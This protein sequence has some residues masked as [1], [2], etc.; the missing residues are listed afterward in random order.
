MTRHS[1]LENI[2]SKNP[3]SRVTTYQYKDKM[4]TK[5]LQSMNNVY[6]HHNNIQQGIHE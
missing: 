5:L 2:N 4:N 6:I 1:P 3:I